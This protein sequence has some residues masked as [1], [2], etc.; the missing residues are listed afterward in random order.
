VNR[1]QTATIVAYLNRANLI[2]AL[3]GQTAVWHDALADVD[4]QAAQ[5]VARQMCR[6]RTSE[7]RWVTPADVL[8]GVRS[9]RAERIA[10]F[11]RTNPNP[12]P[13]IELADWPE[14]ERA[15]TGAFWDAVVDGEDMAGAVAAASRV[16]SGPGELAP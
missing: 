11:Q 12:L 2:P 7:D 9:L 13:P 4:Y 1:E 15:W 8:N 5:T 6:T 10:E 14:L 3:E 16:I